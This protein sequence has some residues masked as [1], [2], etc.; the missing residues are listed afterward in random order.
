MV[1][2]IRGAAQKKI[3]PGSAGSVYRAVK[4]DKWKLALYVT[5]L[6]IKLVLQMGNAFVRRC[7]PKEQSWRG[8]GYE[9]LV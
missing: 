5:S 1:C 8:T 7:K 3:P 9:R 4:L 6:S 2:A